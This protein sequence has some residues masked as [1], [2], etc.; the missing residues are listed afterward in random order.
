L[1]EN[2][3]RDPSNKSFYAYNGG[4]QG[5]D[6]TPANELWQFT[7]SG[8]SGTWSSPGVSASSNFSN[9]LR[10]M[11]AASAFGDGIGYALGGA[12]NSHTTDG[13]PYFDKGGGTDVYTP[14]SGLVT[15]DMA[16][17]SWRNITSATF[18]QTGSFLDGKL[19]YLPAYGAVGLLVPL[20]GL[21]SA[22]G[23]VSAGFT[24]I[25]DF[26]I[27]SM[28]DIASGT[29]HTQTTSGESPPGHLSFCSVGVPGDN[30][31]FEVFAP[32]IR[33]SKY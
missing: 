14:L 1:D 30:G 23:H 20:G 4:A 6:P 10:V 28:Y 8:N 13:P 24:T 9:L 33:V 11:E 18:T 7:P 12:Q 22:A 27:L 17:G 21:T 16:T 19:E 26:A 3:W 25:D 15:Y 32:N 31:T 2:L 29:W 5:Y